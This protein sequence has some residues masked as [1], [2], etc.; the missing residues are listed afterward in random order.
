MFKLQPEQLLGG[1]ALRRQLAL[2]R[3]ISRRGGRFERWPG[4]RLSRDGGRGP[5]TRIHGWS[6]HVS[7]YFAVRCGLADASSTLAERD[8][9]LRES[10]GLRLPQPLT[11][12]S[13]VVPV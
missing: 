13:I 5:E 7:I 10:F 11:A 3:E 1:I 2:S 12:E 8:E 9:L 4:I 6:D